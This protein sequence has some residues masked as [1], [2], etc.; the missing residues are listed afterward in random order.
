M[1]EQH[2]QDFQQLT[3]LDPADFFNVQRHTSDWSNYRT[4]VAA[5]TG[6]ETQT[7]EDT[8]TIAELDPGGTVEILPDPGAGNVYLI[9]SAW[10]RYNP[11]GTNGNQ[12]VKITG[13]WFDQNQAFSALLRTASAGSAAAMYWEYQTGGSGNQYS[14]DRNIRINASVSPGGALPTG[15]GTITVHIE[16]AIVAL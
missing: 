10:C 14:S 9:T 12:V 16:Y 8:F 4:T 5:L 2:I 11:G 13:L 6:L 3:S 1:P 7:Y 15:N